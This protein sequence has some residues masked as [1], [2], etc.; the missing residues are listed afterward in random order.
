[1]GGLNQAKILGGIGSILM[2]IGGF[3]PFIGIVMPLIGLILVII[4]VK[5]IADASQDQKIFSNYLI[6]FVLNIVAMVAVIGI[7]I[8]MLGVALGAAGLSFMDLFQ[9]GGIADPSQMFASI[10]A[11][12]GGCLVALLVGWILLL[13]SAIYLRKSFNAIADHT[14]TSLFKTTAL[15]YLIGAALMIIVIGAIVILIAFIMQIIAFFML[16]DEL[17]KEVQPAP[18]TQ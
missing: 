13:I 15:V 17:P 7:M 16:P 2:L 18:P 9:T 14:K 5:N 10:G 3:I 8:V 6:Y 4:A 12:V 11:L 1:M